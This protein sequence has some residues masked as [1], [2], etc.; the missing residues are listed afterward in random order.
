L[1][2]PSIV[3]VEHLMDTVQNGDI[4]RMDGNLGTV[5]IIQRTEEK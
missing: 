3:G 5:E 2:I 1:K 4:V